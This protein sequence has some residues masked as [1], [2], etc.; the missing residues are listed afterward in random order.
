MS[1]DIT[2]SFK[3]IWEVPNNE[4]SRT[5]P[6]KSKVSSVVKASDMMGEGW[7]LTPVVG[8]SICIHPSFRCG[9]FPVI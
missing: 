8:L 6:M 2:L 5:V 7:L 9:T 3:K 1:K 4:D